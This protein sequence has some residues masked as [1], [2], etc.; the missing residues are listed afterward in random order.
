MSLKTEA[1]LSI[2]L[3]CAGVLACDPAKKVENA[4]EQQQKVAIQA[5]EQRAELAR[6][7][8][9]EAAGLTQEQR[10][11]RADLEQKQHE[12][13]VEQQREAVKLG[14]DQIQERNR[15][16]TDIAQDSINA[17]NSMN[18]ASADL[19]K[20]REDVQ[21]RSRERLNKINAR[22]ITITTKAQNAPAPEK[23]GVSQALDG[24]H[25]TRAAAER[26][27]AALATV[28]AAN[29]KHAEKAVERTLASLEKKLDSAE[30][31]L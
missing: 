24:F 25:E 31:K 26:D 13:V 15:V 7:H 28:A 10:K 1:K 19:D 29:F 18:K 21:S 20:Q 27:I 22:V 4:Q 17:R 16:E 23:S 12:T 30:N 9:Q 2:L 8:T 3:A 5:Q 14:T 6:E 11:E